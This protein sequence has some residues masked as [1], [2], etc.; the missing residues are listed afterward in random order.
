MYKTW[1]LLPPTS[2]P[3]QL[4]PDDPAPAPLPSDD[5][6]EDSGAVIGEVRIEVRDVFDPLLTLEQRFFTHWYPLHLAHVGAAV[7]FDAGR[8]WSDLPGDNNL[9]LLKDIG[10]GLRLGSSRSALGQVIHVDLAFPLDG[11][12]DLKRAQW[13]VT[14]KAG[15]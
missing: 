15:F 9:G 6:L 8:T 11:P 2:S 1:R 13:L 14:T 4:P 5:A 10:V 3:A 12:P 7:F